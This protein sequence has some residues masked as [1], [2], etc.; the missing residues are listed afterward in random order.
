MIILDI[1]ENCSW[2]MTLVWRF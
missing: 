1:R 2:R